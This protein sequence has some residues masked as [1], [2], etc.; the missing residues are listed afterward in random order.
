MLPPLLSHGAGKST[1]TAE[2]RYLLSLRKCGCVEADA[3]VHNSVD[4]MH[5]VLKNPY[6]T[7]PEADSFESKLECTNIGTI[8]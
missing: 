2:C 8:K 5:G 3:G 6:F 1:E 4:N 7:V